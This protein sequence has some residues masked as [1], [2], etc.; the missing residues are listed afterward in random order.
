MVVASWG[1]PGKRWVRWEQ[2]QY[3]RQRDLAQGRASVEGALS[4]IGEVGRQLDLAQGRAPV[5][6]GVSNVGE[7]GR[8][9]DLAQ[10]R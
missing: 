3:R 5:E 6:G 10:G 8:Q 1:S 4:N 7:I 2:A 9:R